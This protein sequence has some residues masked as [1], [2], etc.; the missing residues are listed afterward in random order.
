[1]TMVLSTASEFVSDFLFKEWDKMRRLVTRTF[2][3]AGEVYATETPG[4]EVVVAVHR[5]PYNRMNEAYN[6]IEQWW[7]GT[8]GSPAGTRGRSTEI[9][10]Q[11]WP[12]LRRRL[13]TS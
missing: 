13:C 10:H 5:G 12:T 9:R 2:E 11:I 3:T 7:R 6:A 4:G 1:K 8:G